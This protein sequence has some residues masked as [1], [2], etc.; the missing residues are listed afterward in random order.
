MV[1][2]QKKAAAV[3]RVLASG[4]A[5]EALDL[6]AEPVDESAARKKYRYVS[7]PV[8]ATVR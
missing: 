1:D 2:A 6:A 4:N 7:P 5:F 3:R 8:F